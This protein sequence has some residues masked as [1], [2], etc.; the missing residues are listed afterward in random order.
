[1]DCGS[2]TI[3]PSETSLEQVSALDLPTPKSERAAPD[4][5]DRSVLLTP[6]AV[7]GLGM[8]LK[9]TCWGDLFLVQPLGHILCARLGIRAAQLAWLTVA[10]A[11]G[12][13]GAAFLSV[14]VALAQPQGQP[15]PPISATDAKKFVGTNAVVVGQVAEVNQTEKVIRLNFGQ[16]FPQQDFTAVVFAKNFGAFTNL[17][18][19]EGKTV[20]LSGKVEEYRGHPQMIL[21]TKGQL[22]VLD[23]APTAPAAK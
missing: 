11:L 21:H 18:T 14:P 20:E 7:V 4:Q 22:R 2:S 12:T 5:G 6:G 1:M 10:Y 19:L 8:G 3:T 13:A 15:V 16:K 9:F 23:A 17:A